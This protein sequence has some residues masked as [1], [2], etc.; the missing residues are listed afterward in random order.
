M[1]VQ[2]IQHP[3]IE[4]KLTLMRDKNT[5]SKDFRE[6]L[7]EITTLMTYAVVKDLPAKTVSVKTP[8]TVTQGKRVVQDLISVVAIL[9]AGLGM[10]NGILKLIPHAKVG[11]IGLYRD[12]E[13][14]RPVEYYKKLPSGISKS[15]VILVDPM[16]ATG[17]SA[18]RAIDILKKAG[19]QKMVE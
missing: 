2:V 6:L 3:L 14:L 16:L 18:V 17:Y 12:E 9:R 19:G 11:Y 13:T 5:S 8:L 7:D 15:F 1:K 4:H 10:V